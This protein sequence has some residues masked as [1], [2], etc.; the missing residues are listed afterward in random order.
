M[1]KTD[2]AIFKAY[3]IRGIYPE[4]INEDTVYR[5][6]QAYAKFVSPKVVALGRDVRLS[7]EKLWEAAKNGLVDH[8]V[9]VIDVGVISTDMLYFAV[10][11][12]RYDG[13]ITISASHNP[14]E[15]NGMKLVRKDAIPIS[16][17]SG[18]KDIKDMVLAEYAYKSDIKGNV[19]TKD[20]LQDYLDK[21]LSVIDVKSIQ[22]FKVVAN[23]MF[24]PAVQNVM[25]M[26][27]PIELIPLN[28]V[29]DGNFPKGQ[30]DPLQEQNREETIELIKEK[31][32]D[33]G[34]A[35]DADADRFFLFDQ[36]GRFIPGYYITAF[37]GEYFVTKNSG[38]KVIFDARLTWANQEKIRDAG[39]VPI[40]NKAGHSFFKERMRQEDALFAGEMS[41]HFYFKDFFYAD[42]GLIPFLILLQIFSETGKSVAEIFEPYFENYPI[43]G[44]LNSK[45]SD[46]SQVKFILDRIEAQYAGSRIDK[47]D[48]LSIE[49]ADWRANIRGSNTEPVIRL[50]VEARSPK[51]LREKTG[52]ILTIIKG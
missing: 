27:L 11:N 24:G 43:S 1:Q 2:P 37:L 4:Q 26:N 25:K 34:V 21:C 15:Y 19:E 36:N 5:T 10:A 29:P 35:W 28:E 17:D 45:L 42:N 14:K 41:G 12:Y 40:V 46:P 49:F 48:G 39:G 47:I 50:N 51:V 32:A 33:F 9:D 7:G 16:G 44:E 38:G 20:I 6:A 31:Q 18:I 30:P 8:G 22:N 23:A 13:G 52:E 3:D